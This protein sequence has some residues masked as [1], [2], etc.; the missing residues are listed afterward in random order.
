M[1]TLRPPHCPHGQCP[2]N[3]HGQHD[4]SEETILVHRSETLV[5]LLRSQFSCSSCLSTAPENRIHGKNC[6]LHSPHGALPGAT[7]CGGEEASNGGRDISEVLSLNL[8]PAVWDPLT[9]LLGKSHMCLW[10]A[11]GGPMTG[12]K[13]SLLPAHACTHT[14]THEDGFAFQ[15]HSSNTPLWC[16]PMQPCSN[17]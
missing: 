10:E 14:R 11:S 3:Q 15:C 7:L 8:P 9:Q 17:G 6:S 16:G 2:L 4:E 13:G 1:D 5:T 12:K